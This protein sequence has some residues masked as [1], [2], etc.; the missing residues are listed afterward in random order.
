MDLLTAFAERLRLMPDVATWKH[1]NGKDI[2][3]PGREQQLLNL[4]E[5]KGKALGLNPLLVRAFFQSQF[6][7]AKLYQK[8]YIRSQGE[9]L[10]LAKASDLNQETRP[11]ISALT[12]KILKL[13][14]GLNHDD[15]S[16]YLSGA[17]LK[18][19]SEILKEF[20]KDVIA[21]TLS[22]IKTR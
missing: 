16:V 8:Q 18:N 11:K 6:E 4:L 17:L 14:G 19:H 10:R 3:D 15:R 5:E 9:K 13:L 1:L 20:D 22:T 21:L 2:D 7:A 12:N